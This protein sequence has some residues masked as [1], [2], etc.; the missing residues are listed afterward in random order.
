MKKIQTLCL[1]LLAIFAL[2]NCG[3]KDAANTPNDWESYGLEG[4]VKQCITTQIIDGVT[5]ITTMEF[6]EDG[7]LTLLSESSDDCTPIYT[8]YYDGK[9]NIVNEEYTQQCEG[10]WHINQTD[11]E[12]ERDE[13]GR[14]TKVT[15]KIP[16]GEVIELELYSYDDNDNLIEF[17]RQ[18]AHCEKEYEEHNTY[19]SRGNMVENQWSNESKPKTT[20][21]TYDEQDR[22]IRRTNIDANGN[23]LS[24]SDIT[25]DEQ[26]RIA[27]VNDYN[28]TMLTLEQTYEYNSDS[29]YSRTTI[30]HMDGWEK[31]VACFNK[32]DYMTNQK[33]FAQESQEAESEAT[34]FYNDL[35]TLDSLCI[36]RNGQ[37]ETQTYTERDSHGNIT[38]VAVGP[39]EDSASRSL[40]ILITTREIIYY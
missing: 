10:V 12:E 17:V 28:G 7:F 26:G 13:K 34:F 8:C 33:C 32:Y 40:D 11:L 35:Y 25:Y 18:N 37:T 31:E 30:N 14:I 23:E 5:Y 21:Y 6:N 36:R 9:G 27:T 29:T 24:H 19:D 22:I 20:R 3:K 4:K 1:A 15:Y 2:S 38:R 16:E 39:K